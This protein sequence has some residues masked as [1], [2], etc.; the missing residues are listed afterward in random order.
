MP[1]NFNTLSP[2]TTMFSASSNI[3]CCWYDVFWNWVFFV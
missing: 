3:L 2:K 1:Y